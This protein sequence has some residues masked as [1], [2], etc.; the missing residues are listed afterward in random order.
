M[1]N[2]KGRFGKRVLSKDYKEYGWHKKTAITF[3]VSHK[4]KQPYYTVLK[5]T[6]LS[7]KF[8]P[9]NKGG[10]DVKSICEIEYDDND[11]LQFSIAI[12]LSNIPVDSKY[13]NESK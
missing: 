2:R 4:G 3:Q 6:N 1:D 9:A 5:Q 10:N 13:I 11:T 8:K 7:G 12:D